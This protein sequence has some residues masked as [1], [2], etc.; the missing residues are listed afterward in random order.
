MGHIR[1]DPP[2]TNNKWVG[3]GLANVD[4]FIIRV[5]FGL[6]N[7]DTI[8]ILTRHEHDPLTRIATPTHTGHSYALSARLDV[9]TP[10]SVLLVPLT[11]SPCLNANRGID[12]LEI[13]SLECSLSRLPR[14][15]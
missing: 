1:V 7:V 9:A 10:S 3:F 2:N 15:I 11:F 5:G 4:T 6:A 13:G 8:H 12:L 14:V